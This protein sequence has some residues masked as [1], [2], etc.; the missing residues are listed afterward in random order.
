MVVRLLLLVAAAFLLGGCTGSADDQPTT[1][2]STSTATETTANP[3]EGASTDTVVVP[4]TI[5]ETALLTDVRS[6]RQE[7]YDRVVFEF[8]NGVPGYEVGYVERPII[9]DGSGNEVEV[10]GAAVLRVRMEPALDADLT[11]ESAPRTYTGP[12]RFSPDT[13]TVV[14]L[15]R[16]GGFEA[17][18]T[19]AA[20][21][22]AERPY[23][24][25]ALTDPP[26]IVIDVDTSP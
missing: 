17:V 12:N 16:T 26:R 8:A 22:D 7:G 10:E 20:G 11:Q 23:R 6:V 13:A 19:W 3:L 1:S 14:E 18:L 2:T 25:T 9:A 24:V 21:I 5:T 15:V 4:A